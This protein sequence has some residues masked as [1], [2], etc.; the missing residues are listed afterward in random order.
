MQKTKAIKNV[1]EFFENLIKV[2]EFYPHTQI[3]W[4]K[5]SIRLIGPRSFGYV[6]MNCWNTLSLSKY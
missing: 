2:I 1:M 4:M 3:N 6:H 5:L